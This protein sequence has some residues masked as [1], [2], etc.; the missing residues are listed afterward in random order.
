M[1]NLN[2]WFEIKHFLHEWPNNREAWIDFDY[3]TTTEVLD[4]CL[5]SNILILFAIWVHS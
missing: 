2:H 4:S 5:I 3:R 1:S